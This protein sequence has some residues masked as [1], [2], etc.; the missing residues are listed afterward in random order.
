MACCSGPSAGVRG[1]TQQ[2]S[3][4]TG[5][6]AGRQDVFVGTREVAKCSSSWQGSLCKGSACCKTLLM[7][8]T[9]ALSCFV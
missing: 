6:K 9:I 2:P 4:L 5:A 1:Y 7:V 3:T 8:N